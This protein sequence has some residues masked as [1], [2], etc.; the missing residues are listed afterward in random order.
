MATIVTALYDIDHHQSKR[1]HS[2]NEYLTWFRNVLIINAP[3]VIFIPQDLQSY[4]KEYRPSDYQTKIIL[5]DV[6]EHTFKLDL[7]KEVANINPFSTEY[8]IWLDA[9]TFH[10]PPPF[11][12]KLPWPDKYKIKILKDKFLLAD[13]EISTYI[14]GGNKFAID[15]VHTQFHSEG[16]ENHVLQLLAQNHPEYYYIWYRTSRQYPQLPRPL[17]DRMI[18]CELAQGTFIGE[19][20]AINPNVKLLT[21]ATK[22]VPSRSFERWETTAKHYGY[23]YEILA[24][25]RKWGGVSLGGGLVLGGYGCKLR[26]FCEALK[27]VTAS[28][29]ALSDCTDLFFCGSSDELYD[30]FL[31]I[32]KDSPNRIVVGGEIKKTYLGGKY[33]SRSIHMFFESIKESAQAFPNSG[34]IMGYT[35]DVLKFL[36]S[37]LGYTDDQGACFDAI[38]ERKAPMVVDYKTELVGNVPNYGA[39]NYKSVSYFDYDHLLGRYRN[40]VHNTFPSVLHFPGRNWH[41]MKE[42]YTTSQPGL[43]AQSSPSEGYVG[44]IILA[45]LVIIF[46]LIL[47]ALKQ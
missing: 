14:L 32:T 37:R 5:R 39:E 12:Y 44:W 23:D 22:E 6:K 41:I 4:V 46:V 30:N 34:F 33:N 42:F 38:F 26:I 35:A 25:D 24:R 21:I 13:N 18:P 36:E 28:C 29:V 15:R 7:L 47:L 19:N 16:S 2:F 17:R 9:E 31:N 11:K 10:Q 1:K 40:V 20:Y 8:F 3:M 45:M 43:I 27:S